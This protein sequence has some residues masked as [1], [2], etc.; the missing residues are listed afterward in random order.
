VGD[1]HVHLPSGRHGLRV[2][3]G[4]PPVVV[5]LGPP[6]SIAREARGLRLAQAAPCA[7][8]FAGTSPGELRT[9]LVEGAPRT[10]GALGPG[11]AVALGRA[12]RQA[13]DVRRT[14]SGGLPSWRSRAR[15]LAAYRRR[16][17]ADAIAA[18]GPD[19][20]LAALVVASLPPLAPVSS[21]ASFRLLHGD[22]TLEN[23]VWDPAPRLVDWE[24]WRIG[25]PA[26]DLAYL[27]EVNALPAPLEA[28]VLDG[29]DAPDVAA[30]IDAWRGLCALDAGLW[31]RDAG[32]GLRARRLLR[33]ASALASRGRRG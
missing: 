12:V 33:R 6:E 19:A 21:P 7:A 3:D 10:A 31:Y 30:R 23:V 25:D 18:A 14:R 24:F 9:L 15:D 5:K 13:H 2:V 16:R 1:G 29:Y 28:A 26:E 8:R 11:D 27:V 20:S 4:S 17:A 22:L 32:D